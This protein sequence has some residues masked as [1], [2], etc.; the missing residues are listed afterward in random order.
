M[1][2]TTNQSTQDFMAAFGDVPNEPSPVSVPEPEQSTGVEQILTSNEIGSLIE[3]TGITLP[4][5]DVCDQPITGFCVTYKNDHVICFDC[6]KC[7]VCGLDC[8]ISEINFCLNAKLTIQHA[9]CR[10]KTNPNAKI[11]VDQTELSLL[12]LIRLCFVPDVQLSIDTN[13]NTAVLAFGQLWETKTIEDKFLTLQMMEATY[14]AAY[15][16]VKK[17]PTERK[18]EAV[19]RD[20]VAAVKAMDQAVE[21]R[22]IAQKGK[23]GMQAKFVASMTTNGMMTIAEAKKIWQS[24]GKEWID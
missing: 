6:D 19:K 18:K 14:Q 12:N 23:I 15:L 11:P 21:N 8:N 2:E 17:D 10:M 9:R 1:S 24:Q 22:K 7:S 16:A 3:S 5:C 20:S 13:V 4:H